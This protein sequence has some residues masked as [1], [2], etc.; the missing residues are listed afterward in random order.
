AAAVIGSCLEACF[1]VSSSV[2]TSSRNRF[3]RHETDRG[4]GR[5]RW[6]VVVDCRARGRSAHGDRNPFRYARSAGRDH[7]GLGVRWTDLQAAC[8]GFDDRHGHGVRGKDCFFRRIC[9][10]NDASGAVPA[11][12]VCSEFYELLY[13]L[14][15]NG[16]AVSEAP[17]LRE[18]TVSRLLLMLLV[19]M[20]IQEP[21]PGQAGPSEA[22]QA[23]E[24]FNAGEAIIEHI[25]NNHE[26][27]L[28]ELPRVGGIDFSITKHVFMLWFVAALVFLI[29][30]LTVRRYLRQDRLVP[31]GFMNGL[32]AVVEFVRD[33]IAQP[34]VGGKWVMT[35]T[36]LILTFFFFILLA[37]GIGLV[38]VFDTLAVLDRLVF[39]NRATSFLDRLI[40]GGPTATANFHI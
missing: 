5:C 17:F 19:F 12:T 37:H 36:P 38:T 24:R 8:W 2:F 6:D 25:S 33:D 4:D 23:H 11:G 9:R 28:I 21:A 3:G 20:L 31:S 32:E 7:R 27:P 34:N 13:R 16:S 14:V 22:A 40:H 35:W 15:F 18:V 30:T 39:P 1:S 29:I 26:H 10:H